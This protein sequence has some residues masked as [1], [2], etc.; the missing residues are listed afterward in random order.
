VKLS[1]LD[2]PK[3]L[4]HNVKSMKLTADII[5]NNWP[6]EY[7]YIYINERLTKSKRAQFSQTRSAMKE[8]K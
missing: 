4:I 2:M 3:N 8:N 5:N 6:K 1:T 7:I